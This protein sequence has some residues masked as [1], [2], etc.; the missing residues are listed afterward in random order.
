MRVRVLPFARVRELL[1]G[2]EIALELA[3]G[4]QVSDAWNALE[5][6][7]PPLHDLAASTRLARNG[8]IVSGIEPLCDGDVVALLPP[9]GGG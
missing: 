2:P 3:E 6:L 8:R 1:D 7:A 4:A 9:V 5:R